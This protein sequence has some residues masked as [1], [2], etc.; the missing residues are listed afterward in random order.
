MT[1]YS[2]NFVCR[3][4]K[5]NKSGY[6]PVEMYVIFNKERVFITLPRKEKPE[7]FKKKMNGKRNNDL[8]E[9]CSFYHSTVQTKVNELLQNNI[10]VTSKN[11]KEY[12]LFGSKIYSI[13]DLFNDFF[14]TIENKVM[15]K[16][17]Y[18]KY[19]YVKEMLSEIIDLDNDCSKLNKS[20]VVKFKNLLDERYAESTVA[21][22]FSKI[23][24]V[25]T[26]GI[27]SNKIESNVCD[28]IKVNKKM[29]EVVTISEND[30]AVLCN[31]HFSIPRLEK[32]RELAVFA[33]C[34][35]L[36]F[37]DIVQLKKEDFSFENGKTIIVKKR[38][39]TKV[40][41]YSVLLDEGKKIVEK[42]N[43]DL[44]SLYIS[45]QRFNSYLKEIQD[46]CG[47]VSVHSLHCHL[48]RHFYLSY[49][50]NHGIPI[51]IV[52]KCA[53]HSSVKITQHYAKEL[54]STIKNKVL[55]AF[56]GI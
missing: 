28:G 23:K 30:F 51:E 15:S 46:M 26:F 39:K 12:F 47:I 40:T 44:S 20:I 7:E 29:K 37:A 35:G 14:K 16:K 2:I 24:T 42:Y 10:E 50:I 6:S 19:I 32:V 45:N 49:L 31:K 27:N 8:K 13:N 5:A 52:S 34:S 18:L 53:G 21:V 22:Y 11:I 56:N 41:Y 3:Q 33:C 38:I 55:S 9:F 1:S 4:S 25:I 48:F 17:N 43:Y 54:Q 36:S